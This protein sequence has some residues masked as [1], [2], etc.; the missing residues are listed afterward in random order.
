MKFS[1]LATIMSASSLGACQ[2]EYI[3][4][5]DTDRRAPCPMLNTV[6]NHG[7]LPRNGL[8]ISMDDLA[9]GLAESINLDPA[10]TA[11]FGAAAVLTSTTGNP[12]TFNLDDLVLQGPGLI[13]HDASLSRADQYWG[14]ALTLNTTV[15]GATAAF[16]TGPTIDA[17]TAKA[18][19][20]A[21]IA[22]SKA[23][24]PEFDL[25]PTI[26]RNSAIEWAAILTVFEEPDNDPAVAAPAVTEW[27]KT[28][29][30]QE[31][32]PFE[33]GWTRSESTVTVA[34][35]LALAGQLTGTA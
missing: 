32:L 4:P 27:I 10:A 14:N 21:R 18:A 23:T 13:A 5:S 28:V 7:Y 1:T 34:P 31:R 25:P 24:N 9:Q 20:D 3:A 8:N 26:L 6:T 30:E 2:N 12:N 33:E 29:F 16:F 35:V 15:W 22:T 17:A 19:R 11:I